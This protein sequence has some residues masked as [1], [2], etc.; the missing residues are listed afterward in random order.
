[1]SQRRVPEDTGGGNNNTRTSLNEQLTIT[2]AYNEDGSPI[3]GEAVMDARAHGG[4]LG[5]AYFGNNLFNETFEPTHRTPSYSGG[6]YGTPITASHSVEL[7]Q[8]MG[9]NIPPM[10]GTIGAWSPSTTTTINISISQS[11]IPTTGIGGMFSLYYTLTGAFSPT[12]TTTVDMSKF[13]LTFSPTVTSSEFFTVSWEVLKVPQGGTT[14]TYYTSSSPT[15][16]HILPIYF[17]SGMTAEHY[18]TWDSTVSM[19][20]FH[21][22]DFSHDFASLDTSSFNTWTT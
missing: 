8:N 21:H 11:G 22:L 5:I 2:P 14:V 16:S 4:K 20:R 7:M 10:S 17:K 3:S 15:T 18:M 1:M 13:P 19:G 9:A 6:S 12:T